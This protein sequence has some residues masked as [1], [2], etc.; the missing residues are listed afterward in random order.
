MKIRERMSDLLRE[1]PP[2]APAIEFED[3]WWSWGQLTAIAGEL[4]ALLDDVE[5]RDGARVGVVLENRP[6]HVGVVVALVASNRC[7]VTLSPLQP[8]ERLAA[9]IGRSGVPIVVA[10]SEVLARPGILAAIRAAPALAVELDAEGSVRVVGGSLPAGDLTAPGIAVEMLTSGTTGPPKRVRLT[11]HQLDVS[12]SSSAQS[13]RGGSLLSSSVAVV[14]TPLVHIG[15]LWGVLSTLHVGRRIALLP[16]FQL[17][18]WVRAVEKHRPRAAGLVPAAMRS[19]LDANIAPERLASLQV[20]TSGTAPCP[21][22]LAD[23]LTERYGIRV[24]MTYGATE[25]AGAVAG[26]T[27]PLHKE[28]WDRK[29]GSAGRPFPGVTLRITGDDARVLPPGET[30]VLEIRTA[31]SALGYKAWV[32]TSDLAC[33]DEDH[34]LWIRGR[35]DDAII[36]GGFKIQPDVVKNVLEQHPGVREAAVA[37]LPEQRLGAVPVAA[38]ER[39]PGADPSVEELFLLCRNQLTPYEVPAHI[40]V[41]DHLPRTPSMKVPRVELLELVKA[42]IDRKV[43]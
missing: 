3:R 21:P 28:W 20:V 26:W 18:P 36:R 37:G 8:P 33:L 41:V 30:G 24:L 19:L 34:F 10:S 15:G 16:R 39:K 14:S 17:D 31:Q 32:R 1:A 2:D 29:K 11:E 27:L 22:D 13:P 40:V 9:D 6:E 43:A 42:A 25:F 35:A 38:V 7:L 23:A 5:L 4:D 12:M